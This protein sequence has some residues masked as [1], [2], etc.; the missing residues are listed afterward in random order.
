M[1]WFKNK[2]QPSEG[3]Y[4]YAAARWEKNSTLKNNET[5]CHHG[6][7]CI[8]ILMIWLFCLF[9]HQWLSDGQT[10]IFLC[11]PRWGTFPTIQ[12]MCFVTADS[13]SLFSHVVGKCAKNS[14]KKHCDAIQAKCVDVV[15]I[16]V[17]HVTLLSHSIPRLPSRK[18][19]NNIHIVYGV[20]ASSQSRSVHLNMKWKLW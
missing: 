17:L 18:L 15:L 9:T 2:L 11:P 5:G 6:M 20:K 19:C 12:L 10:I 14:K 16:K 7:H 3:D 13:R 1:P 8:C 4:F